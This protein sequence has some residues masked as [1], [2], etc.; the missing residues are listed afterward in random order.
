MIRL[1]WY[2]LV[3]S[4]KTHEPGRWGV[5]GFSDPVNSALSEYNGQAVERPNTTAWGED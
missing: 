1:A 3:Y 4:I 5:S 2:L